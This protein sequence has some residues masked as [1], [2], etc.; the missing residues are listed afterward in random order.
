MATPPCPSG[1]RA[2]LAAGL[3]LLLLLRTPARVAT[4][5]LGRAAHKGNTLPGPGDCG[6]RGMEGRIMG[7]TDAPEGKWPWQA[8]LRS[9]GYHICG[10]SIIN[11]YWILTA[12]H[13]LDK[14]RNAKAYNV[15]VGVVNIHNPGKYTQRFG[16]H[17]IIIHPT[18]QKHHPVGGDIALM[19][20]KTSIV[21]SEAVLPVCL[22]SSK[23]V[24]S[25]VNCWATGWGFTSGNEDTSPKLQ[26]VQLPLIPTQTCQQ[27]FGHSSYITPDMLCAGDLQNFKTVCEGDS[28][29]PFV[30]KIDNS[31]V[32]IGVVS[33]G[34][35][36]AN[37]T[38]PAVFARVT[39]FS[40]WIKDKVEKTPLPFQSVPALSPTLL[41]NSLS[42]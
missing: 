32:Q 22:A 10:G 7:G 29:G 1:P 6:Q 19:Q 2:S 8:S 14:N 23:M 25:G 27:I 17:K 38:Y 9:G 20:L 16:V 15:S 11:P 31:W 33:W 28:G 18:Y 4:M 12:A 41:L 36:C 37:P 5:A 13:C 30:C 39:H 26:E 3:L 35:T 21:Y 42:P 24:I 34:R 40:D